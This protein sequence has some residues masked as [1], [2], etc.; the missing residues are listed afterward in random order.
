M[1]KEND[2][3]KIAKTIV[4]EI[5]QDVKTGNRDSLEQA[6]EALSEY[7]E[8]YC[9]YYSDCHEIL[10]NFT[11]DTQYFDTYGTKSYNDIAQIY[12]EKLCSWVK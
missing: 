3:V 7:I 6:K 8:S 12:A 4:E 2:P 11:G 10:K 1:Q 9:I 5:K